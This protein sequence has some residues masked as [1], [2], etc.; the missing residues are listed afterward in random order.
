MLLLLVAVSYYVYWRY[1]RAGREVEQKYELRIKV[2]PIALR[3]GVEKRLQHQLSL[4]N[5][6]AL[7]LSASDQ[8]NQQRG[9]SEAGEREGRRVENGA[10]ANELRIQPNQRLFL[11]DSVSYID[12]SRVE[13]RSPP[14]Q[15]P[16]NPV[17]GINI[18]YSKERTGKGKT[19]D[20]DRL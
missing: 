18:R 8:S 7:A 9:G 16:E 11:N 20:E 10:D 17:A 15:R 4:L 5:R 1:F 12:Q 19:N 6:S 13:V 14:S 2:K 3:P